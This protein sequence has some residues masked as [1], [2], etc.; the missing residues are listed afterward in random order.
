MVC[1]ETGQI[2]AGMG[3]IWRISFAILDLVDPTPLAAEVC[4]AAAALPDTAA[5]HWESVATEALN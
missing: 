3:Q 4:P 2:H 1:P 5:H